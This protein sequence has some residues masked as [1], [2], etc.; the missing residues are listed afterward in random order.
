[1]SQ[2][3]PTI[4]IAANSL[5]LSVKLYL[6]MAILFQVALNSFA[7][8]IPSDSGLDREKKRDFKKQEKILNQRG[9]RFGDNGLASKISD[10]IKTR[11]ICDDY[12]VD[13]GIFGI[14]IGLNK[15]SV[16]NYDHILAQNKDSLA[17]LPYNCKKDFI[18]AYKNHKGENDRPED[19]YCSRRECELIDEAK[20]LYIENIEALEATLESPD[21]IVIEYDLSCFEDTT[22]THGEAQ[23]IASEITNLAAIV[24]DVRDCTPLQVG[25]SRVTSE[26]DRLSDYVEQKYAVTNIGDDTYRVDL[27]INFIPTKSLKKTSGVAAKAL[28]RMRKCVSQVNPFAKDSLGRKLQFNILTPGETK[29]LPKEIRP[30]QVDIAVEKADF[31]RMN[32]RTY[33]EN[34]DCATTIHEMMH[35]MGIHD[36]YHENQIG[37]YTHK[38]NGKVIKYHNEDGSINKKGMEIVEE[39]RDDYNLELA[40]QCRAI[41]QKETIMKTTNQFLKTVIPPVGVC[42]CSLQSG[43]QKDMCHRIFTLDKKTRDHYYRMSSSNFEQIPNLN[44]YCRSDDPNV[45]TTNLGSIN[46]IINHNLISNVL[47]TPHQI[48]FTKNQAS[49]NDFGSVSLYSSSRTCTCEKSNEECIEVI[50]KIEAISQNIKSAEVKV[51]PFPSRLNEDLSPEQITDPKN[52]I[53]FG[54][55]VDAKNSPPLFEN[56]YVEK[57]LFPGCDSRAS[58]YVQCIEKA[59]SEEGASCAG[60]PAYCS[61]DSWLSDI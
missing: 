54:F 2:N 48:S 55:E 14:K 44:T 52:Q 16:F 46:E 47:K 7:V 4:A 31:G 59:Y 15:K 57:V 5:K 10:K 45:T 19:W 34:I 29:S 3:L 13:P 32:S 23:D 43:A 24:R 22:A 39:N 35:L 42:E 1:M 51:C 28:E 6:L 50:N 21:E 60:T 26:N 38:T 25:E 36:E 61:D 49:V 40:Y 11:A 27:N 41:P 18:A 20:N 53:A 12:Q 56:A 8:E 58:K 30:P 33:T 17:A 9:Y 37:T